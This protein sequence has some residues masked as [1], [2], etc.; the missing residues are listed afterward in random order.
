MNKF[1]FTV[2]VL[3]IT[4][5]TLAFASLAQAQATRTWVSGVGDDVNP[6]S[7]TAPC[8]TW[9]GAISKT[10]AGGEIDALDPGGFGA[11]T[12]TK[13]ITLDGQGTLASTLSSGVQG[14]VINAGASDIVILRNIQITGAGTTLGTNGINFIAGKALIIENCTI[15]FYSQQGVFFQ[16]AAADSHLIMKNVT[17]TNI[18][19]NGVL[20][21]GPNS[22]VFGSLKEV[23]TQRCGSNG[24]LADSNSRV[25]AVA[26]EFSGNGQNGFA[27]TPTTGGS[28]CFLENCTATDNVAS[29]FRADANA[30]VSISNCGSYQNDGANWTFAGGGTITSFGNNQ[31]RNNSSDN[32]PNATKARQ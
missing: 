16:P 14:I 29:G 17:I 22:R 12:I 27:A 15:S 25:T 30:N 8:K 26:C 32:A 1:R 7:R 13:S 4:I 31:S 10:A 3:A 2:N 19:Q 28:E 9:A 21:K 20:L 11:V 6:C 24:I 23:R 5:F 18:G